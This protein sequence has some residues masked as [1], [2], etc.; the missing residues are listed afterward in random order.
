MPEENK[1]HVHV[2]VSG[3]TL[4][5]VAD[6]HHIKLAEL[7]AENPQIKDP[8]KVMIGQRIK[9]PHAIAPAPVMTTPVVAPAAE[10]PT[11]LAAGTDVPLGGMPVTNSLNDAEKYDTYSQFFSRYGV[12]LNAL[13]PG[14]RA[15][16]GLRVKSNT[17]VRG[18]AGEYNDRLVVAWREASGTKR[19]REF[20]ANTEPSS[21]Y[22]DTPENKR[23]GRKIMGA[24]ADRDGR[25]DLGC[26]PDGLYHFRKGTSPTYGNVLAP[27][28]DLFVIRDV[29]HDGDFDA[30]DQAASV[31]ALL[32]SQKSILFHKGGNDITGSAGCQTLKPADFNNFWE[33]LGPQNRFQYVVATVA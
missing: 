5:K 25:R 7:L 23:L 14:T 13:D 31:H 2:I 11:P 15:L 28:S 21:R 19:V 16:L 8:N 29:D 30:A 1:D 6:R 26:L 10:T 3:D 22:E 9:I 4:S 24:D 12:T 32:N 17:R 20:I 33:A 27:E 18:G